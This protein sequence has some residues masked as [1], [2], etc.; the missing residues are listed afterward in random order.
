LEQLET[1]EH[2]KSQLDVL[3]AKLQR[4]K[5]KMS[6]VQKEHFEDVAGD[7]VDNFIRNVRIMPMS[8]AV[9]YIVGRKAAFDVFKDFHNSGKSKVYSGH[10]DYVYSHTRGYGCASKPEDY[11]EEFRKFVLNNM[12]EIEALSIVCQRP[13]ELTRAELKSL[14]LELDRN[15][16]TETMLNTAWNEM[17]NQDIVADII[18]FI[19]QQAL[20]DALI[21]HDTRI[22]KAVA[23]VKANH[24]ELN[25]IQLKWLDRIETQLLNETIL[26]RETFE[27]EA[28]RNVGGFKKI[29]MAFGN[30]LD[31]I[32]DEINEAL[33]QGA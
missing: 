32:I 6:D 33:Y 13:K 19:R 11:I 28:F 29:N 3:I 1:D 22:R 23:F 17:T 14:K 7:T 15:N 8:Q 20:G 24:P 4:N 18:S 12:N 2:R 26:N 30:K 9:S 31:I 5:K 25:A 21:S 16:F 27:L 10:E